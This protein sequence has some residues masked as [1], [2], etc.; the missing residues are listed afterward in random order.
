MKKTAQELYQEV[1][2]SLT[3]GQKITQET[4]K[5]A[6]EKLKE[7][8]AQDYPDA[9]YWMG[10]FWYYGVIEEEDEDEAVDYYQKAA[11]LGSKGASDT[12]MTYAM[13]LPKPITLLQRA[14]QELGLI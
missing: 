10:E 2:E 14:F 9:V 8:A 7:A 4:I 3:P 1:V 11:N 12:M 6:H 13:M 5:E